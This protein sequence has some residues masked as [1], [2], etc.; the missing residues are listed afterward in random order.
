MLAWFATE[1]MQLHCGYCRSSRSGRPFLPASYQRG[2]HFPRRRD[3]FIVLPV[4]V[5]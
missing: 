5:G 4:S 1:Q 3:D 2:L